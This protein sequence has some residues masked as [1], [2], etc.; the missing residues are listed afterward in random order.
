MQNFSQISTHETHFLECFK[1]KSE[2]WT[3]SKAPCS[4][5]GNNISSMKRR[6]AVA[7]YTEPI[8]NVLQEPENLEH[9]LMYMMASWA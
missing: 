1:G 5:H 9:S 4:S 8:S 7:R 6:K 2:L 3:A